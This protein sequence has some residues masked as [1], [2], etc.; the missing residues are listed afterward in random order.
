LETRFLRSGH[1][2]Y[3]EDEEVVA[4]V[5]GIVDRVNKLITVKALKS[6]YFILAYLCPVSNIQPL[7]YSPEV[8]DLVVG[9]I[10]EVCVLFNAE[11]SLDFN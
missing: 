10:S 11:V 6:R 8:G 4:S 9:R 3:I 2:T 5:A 7:R 1:G